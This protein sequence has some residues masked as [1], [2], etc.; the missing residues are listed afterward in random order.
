MM[1]KYSPKIAAYLQVKPQVAHGVS[2]HK[3]PEIAGRKISSVLTEEAHKS[4]LT[5][6]AK[7]LLATTGKHLKNATR[8][9]AMKYQAWR[10]GRVRQSTLSLD[11]QAINM[12]FHFGQPLAFAISSIATVVEDRAYSPS[13][14]TYLRSR[15]SVRLAFSI[16]LA[17]N[18]G[19][20]SME[21]ITIASLDCLTPSDRHWHSQR[22]HGREGDQKFAVHGKGGL[23]REVRLE[24]SLAGQLT[25][26][27]RPTKTKISHRSAI[28]TSHYDLIAGHQFACVFG[29]LSKKELGFS[30]GGHGLRHSFAQERFLNLIYLGHEP[31]VALQILSEELGHFS[32]SNTLAYL[33]T[34]FSAST[35]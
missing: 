26:F 17:I 6:Y 7:W 15:A 4:A 34:R 16:D 22:F 21:L 5:V 11:R 24:S 35:A 19:L 30:H 9:D 25:E 29:R 1:R 18:A 31:A 33:G 20:R 12:H 10:A 2:K 28:L 14:V 23:L 32:V 3:H 13:Q 8:E 27:A